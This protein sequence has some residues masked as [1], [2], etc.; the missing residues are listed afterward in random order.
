MLTAFLALHLVL[1][2]QATDPFTIFRPSVLMSLDERRRLDEGESVARVLPGQHHEVAIF[3]AVPVDADG[4]RLRGR[5]PRWL[6]WRNGAVARRAPLEGRG[7]R[8]ASGVAAT[9]RERPAM[10]ARQAWTPS[11]VGPSDRAEIRRH[12]R[13][14]YLTGRASRGSPRGPWARA[15]HV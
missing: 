1:A 7:I 4:D 12:D 14:C 13:L 2:V 15:L 9:N 8:C 3:A 10:T 5:C 6:L 11:V